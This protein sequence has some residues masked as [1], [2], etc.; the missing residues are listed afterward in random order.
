M[1]SGS[2]DLCGVSARKRNNEK[3]TNNDVT[4]IMLQ[5]NM[6]SMHSRER[7]EEM[8][9]ELEGYRWDALWLCETWRHEQAEICETS[10]TT[11]FHG[12]W[13][14]RQ[15]TRSRNYFEQKVEAKNH[16]HWMHQRACQRIKLMSVYFSHS[17]Y[18]DHH[19]EKCTKRSRN[20]LQIAKDTFLKL[21][22]TS[23]LNWDLITEMNVIVLA[24]TLQRG[25][26]MRW[27]D[28]TLDDVTR[29]HS[30]QRDERK[31]PQ[32]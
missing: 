9:C 26:H 32:K 20:T 27:L 13:K 28:E 1:M 10:Q 7:I 11:H 19:I 3:A 23:M 2:K 8:V 30:T 24:D 17:G 18:A 5:K 22:E 4:I 31:T 25:K 21:V 29:L 16:R 12:I 6:R 14:V 15:Q